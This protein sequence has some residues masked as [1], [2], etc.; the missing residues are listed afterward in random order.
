MHGVNVMSHCGNIDF[1][2][3]CQLEGYCLKGYVPDPEQS[4]SGVTI[5]SGFDLGQRSAQE[6]Q[7]LFPPELAAKLLPYVGKIKADAVRALQL[8]P[9]LISDAEAVVIN[10][11]AKRVATERLVRSWNSSQPCMPFNDLPP[12][13]ATVIASVAFQY[14]D[15]AKRTPNFWRQ[16]VAGQWQDAVNNLRH[17][18]DKYIT[19][20]NK[21]AERL[22]QW[23]KTQV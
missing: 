3:I 12:A 20:R 6:L 19:R 17:F 13:C 2:F 10:A 16:V 22:Q 8:Q 7:S 15:L 14:G 5:A 1:D 23:I 9:L 11:Q 4:H 18:G 21:E